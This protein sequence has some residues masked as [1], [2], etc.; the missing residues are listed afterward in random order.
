MLIF[1]FFLKK[2]SIRSNKIGPEA[3]IIV[4]KHLSSNSTLKKIE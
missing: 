2:K 1:F 4:A 3:L